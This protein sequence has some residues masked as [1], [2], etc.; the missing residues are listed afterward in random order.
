MKN[1]FEYKGMWFLPNSKD[2]KVS[3]ILLYDGDSKITLELFG[4]FENVDFMPKAGDE[5]VIQGITEDSKHITLYKSFPIKIGGGVLV[6][7]EEGG[8]PHTIYTVNYIFEGHHFDSGEDLKFQTL[9]SEIHHLDE[10][11]GVSG[12]KQVSDDPEDRRKGEMNIHYK[13][14]EQINFQLDSGSKGQFNFVINHPGWS[15]F[16]KSVSLNQRL[17]FIVGA[18]SDLP[19][20]EMLD[21]LFKFQNFLILA[22]YEKT[23]PHS[24]I[25][26]S[27]NI[28]DYFGH[29]KKITLY[30]A[31]SGRD[32]VSKPK[33]YF[34]F[35][36]AYGHVADSF[37]TLI[38]NWYSKYELLRPAFNLLFEQFY[39]TE[40]FTENSFLNLAQAAETFHARVDNHTKM[41]KEE[42]SK[43]KKHILESTSEEYHDWLNEQF[44]FGNNLNLHRRL[45][46]I[47]VK[48]SNPTLD[49]ILGDKELFV[50]QVKWSRNYYTHYSESGKKNA[51]K[52]VELFYLAEKL[53]ILLTCS[54]L[55]EIGFDQ[56]LLG[57]CL[58]QNRRRF[59]NHL[60]KW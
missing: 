59:F 12:F 13:L 31:I 39:N 23:Y 56:E 15:I 17:Q 9:L 37:P 45:T 50:S 10:W 43:M 55:L 29:K 36:F 14:P 48:Y 58:E 21:Y 44:N 27:E 2:N 38:S 40:R 1:S 4:N 30:F 26:S 57:K 60:V 20:E 34:E 42:F 18:S 16:Q 11:V 25:L 49:K 19:F 32:T 5:E 6:Q 51:L 53:K 46:E 22:L 54:F 41:P 52:G 8:I 28:K 7:G 3:G 35:L 33:P 47:V 24:V